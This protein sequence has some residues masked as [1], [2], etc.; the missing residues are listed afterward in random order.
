MIPKAPNN[1][2]FMAKFSGLWKNSKSE[3]KKTVVQITKLM[4]I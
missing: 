1:F 4:Q 3:T 2:P